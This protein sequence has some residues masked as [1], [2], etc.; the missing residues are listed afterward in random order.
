[1]KL[2]LSKFNFFFIKSMEVT[3]LAVFTQSGRHPSNLYPG[4]GSSYP[5]YTSSSRNKSPVIHPSLYQDEA[6][7]QQQQQLQNEQRIFFSALSLAN[8][9]NK[10]TVTFTTFKTGKMNYF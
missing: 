9:F 5:M 7:L 1:M 4:L 6:K 8:L 2:F 10:G 3:P